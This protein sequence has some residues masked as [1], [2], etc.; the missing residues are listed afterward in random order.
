MKTPWTMFH[1]PSPVAVR[2]RRGEGGGFVDEKSH[3]RMARLEAG[4]NAVVFEC[5]G[6]G[7]AD[8]ADKGGAK[9][10]QNLRLNR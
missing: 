1:Y 5:L 8:G 10:F 2:F 6:G 3:F 7:G 9:R 4:F